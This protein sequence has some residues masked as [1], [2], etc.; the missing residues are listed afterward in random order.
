MYRQK[1][2]S[3]VQSKIVTVAFDAINTAISRGDLEAA[4]RNAKGL[5]ARLPELRELANKEKITADL[6]HV[7]GKVYLQMSH[8]SDSLSYYRKGKFYLLF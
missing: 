6:Y 3:S 1:A 5:L 8:F 2:Q 7:L 4:L